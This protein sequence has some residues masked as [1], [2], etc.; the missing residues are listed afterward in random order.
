MIMADMFDPAKRSEIM[1]KAHSHDTTPEIRV[2]KLLH[3]MGMR[4]KEKAIG[5]F[6]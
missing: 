6:G 2:R 5:K 1:S 3:C 4:N